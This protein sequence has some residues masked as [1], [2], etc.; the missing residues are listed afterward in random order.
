[1]RVDDEA[2]LVKLVGDAPDTEAME[3]ADYLFRLGRHYAARF[4]VG[5][6]K[7]ALLKAVRTFR[8]LTNN[9]AFRTY[10]KLDI[11]LFY[12]GYTL[13]TGKYMKEARAVYDSLLKNFPSSIYI[14]EAH[15]A[16][17]DY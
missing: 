14:P 9:P 6:Q 13:Q 10:P 4:H 2:T 15:L 17:G 16:F 5:N 3:K 11:A 12:Y 1:M 7:D 8:D